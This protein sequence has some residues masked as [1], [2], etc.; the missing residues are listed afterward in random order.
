MAVCLLCISLL[1]LRLAARM[2]FLASAMIPYVL[3]FRSLDALL[4]RQ[5]KVA[6]CLSAFQ[7]PLGPLGSPE[8]KQISD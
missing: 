2:I 7:G 6:S 4:N 3:L 5:V 8:A 1:G